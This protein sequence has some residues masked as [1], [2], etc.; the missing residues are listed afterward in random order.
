MTWNIFLV[1]CHGFSR[2]CYILLMCHSAFLNFVLG[3][4]DMEYFC[5]FVSWFIL[6]VLHSVDVS[7]FSLEVFR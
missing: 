5:S 1:L 2:R 4:Y 7:K 3:K 6:S